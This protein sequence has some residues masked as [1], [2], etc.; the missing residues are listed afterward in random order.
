ML[1][2]I[3]RRSTARNLRELTRIIVFHFVSSFLLFLFFNFLSNLSRDAVSS[4]VSVL[5]GVSIMYRLV[6][7]TS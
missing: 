1:N 7:V 5:P 6:S 4:N 3:N 2:R